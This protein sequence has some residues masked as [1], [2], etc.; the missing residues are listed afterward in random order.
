[1]L[2]KMMAENDKLIIEVSGHA[3]FLGENEYNNQLSKARAEKVVS[4]LTS[5]GIDK[6]RLRAQGYGENKP[7]KGTDDSE[8][9]RSLNRR[10][11]FMIMAQ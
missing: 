3:D 4:Y 5:K 2:H 10:T 11:E 6:S 8:E 7:V 9:G 1:M